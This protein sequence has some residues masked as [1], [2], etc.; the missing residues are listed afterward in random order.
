MVIRQPATPAAAVNT[1]SNY[2]VKKTHEANEPSFSLAESKQGVL[3][4]AS[5][6]YE[7]ER[8]MMMRDKD[9][10]NDGMN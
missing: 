9:K 6:V 7:R 1:S 3:K 2:R 8:M 5:K 10:H 4:Q